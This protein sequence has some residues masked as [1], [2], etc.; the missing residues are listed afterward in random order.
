MNHQALKLG[1]KTTV[2][3]KIAGCILKSQVYCKQFL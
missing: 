1:L 3:K 2:L